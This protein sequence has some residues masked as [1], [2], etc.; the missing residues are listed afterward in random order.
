MS[1]FRVG[2]DIEKCKQLVSW[3]IGGFANQVLE[4]VRH[5]GI[6][7]LDYKKIRAEFDSYHHLIHK[8]KNFTDLYFIYDL[9]EDYFAAMNLKNWRWRKPLP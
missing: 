9:I 2:L 5:S 8:I 7:V 6:V 4:K 1:R 3:T